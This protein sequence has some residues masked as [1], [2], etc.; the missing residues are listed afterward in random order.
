MAAVTQCRARADWAAAPLAM[1]ERCFLKRLAGVGAA[2]L[3]RSHESRV[4]FLDTEGGGK[5][6]FYLPGK[7]YGHAGRGHTSTANKY[8]TH[9]L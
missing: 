6:I 2:N 8:M 9:A 7:K 5:G 3:G 1:L 4:L